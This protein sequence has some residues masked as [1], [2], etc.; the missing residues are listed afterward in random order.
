MTHTTRTFKMNN[1]D[2]K[3][4]DVTVNFFSLNNFEDI[5]S[6]IDLQLVDIFHGDP[7]YPI[8]VVKKEIKKLIKDKT[9]ELS[10]G[11]IAE[12]FLH[13][14]LRRLGF[15]QQCLFKNLEED[16]LKKAFDGFYKDSDDFWIVES[17][18]AYKPPCTH[19]EKVR[20]AL[21]DINDKLSDPENN[22]PW[23]NAVNHMKVL[24]NGK[25]D[26]SLIKRVKKLSF[27]YSANITHSIAEFNVI[28][29][30]TLFITNFQ[31]EDEITSELKETIS[32]K[33]IK[34]IVVIC[35]DNSLYKSFKD[36]FEIEEK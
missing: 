1:V 8:E 10:H 25:K 15:T 6:E 16:S 35:I 34:N 4:I 13:I 28:P 11:I 27:D 30:S 7:D 24:S 3:Q 22:N 14:L 29:A 31:N 5:Q 33:K 21:Y 26:E 23:D 36:Y 2:S 17:K 19:R 12:F 9:D 18:S 20:E 32:K